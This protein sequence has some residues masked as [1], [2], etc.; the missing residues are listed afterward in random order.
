[1]NATVPVGRPPPPIGTGVAVNVRL[2]P[3]LAVAG[4]NAIDVAV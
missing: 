1:M 3:G 4:L 2:W